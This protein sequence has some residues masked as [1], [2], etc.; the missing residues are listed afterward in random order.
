MLRK[1]IGNS[2]TQISL[3]SI[4]LHNGITTLP[5]NSFFACVN[6]EELVIP[7]S[8]TEIGDF[9]FWSCVN[10]KQIKL[11]QNIKS[12]GK[13]VFGYCDKITIFAEEDSYADEYCQE[14]FG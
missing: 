1:G 9:A 2:I 8:V 6:L 13:N 11:T 10:L 3:W 5:N 4:V 14:L 12:I 7:D